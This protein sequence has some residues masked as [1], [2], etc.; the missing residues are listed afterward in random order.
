MFLKAKAEEKAFDAIPDSLIKK[1]GRLRGSLISKSR[2]RGFQNKFNEF[3]KRG[4][5]NHSCRAL[6]A[7]DSHQWFVFCF[8]FQE[9]YS[10]INKLQD[11]TKLG[12]VT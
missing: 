2:E 9:F 8:F 5:T 4:C 10:A 6:S 3:G 7:S 11:N 12:R 1:L